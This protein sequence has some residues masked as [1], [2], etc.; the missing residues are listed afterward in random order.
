VLIIFAIDVVQ[1]VL[2]HLQKNSS[3]WVLILAKN[4]LFPMLYIYFKLFKNMKRKKNSDGEIVS[5]IVLIL[6]YNHECLSRFG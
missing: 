2:V 4:E 5:A 6:T 1:I 3:S